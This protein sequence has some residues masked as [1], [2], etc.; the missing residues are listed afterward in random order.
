MTKKFSDI[1]ITYDNFVGKSKVDYLTPFMG[2]AVLGT[3]L[4]SF[5][6]I[7]ED[8][9]VNEKFSLT[10]TKAFTDI[11]SSPTDEFSYISDFARS[12][13][14]TILT[15]EFISFDVSLSAPVD[16]VSLADLLSLSFNMSFNDSTNNEDSSLIE[17][18]KSVAETQQATD[19]ITLVADFN[20]DLNDALESLDNTDLLLSKPVVD[21]TTNEDL[22]ALSIDFNRIFNDYIAPEELISKY[23]DKTA[24][25]DN[26]STASVVH[27]LSTKPFIDYQSLSDLIIVDSIKA[28]SDTLISSEVFERVV[29]FRREFNDSYGLEDFLS[30]A[31][32]TTFTDSFSSSDQLSMMPTKQFTDIFSSTDDQKFDIFKSITD[33][34]STTDDQKFDIFKSITDS[35]YTT[36]DQLSM[37]PTKQFTDIFSSTDDQKFDIFKSITDSFS[38]SD[39]QL[40]MMPTKQFTDIFSSSDQLSMMPT[41]QFTDIF[42]SSDDQKFDIFKSI[43]DEASVEDLIGVPDGITWEY[44]KTSNESVNASEN[45]NVTFNAY[46]S[47]IDSSQ[48]TEEFN[49]NIGKSFLDDS[50]VAD[51]PTFV[52]AA[53]RSFVETP[54]TTDTLFLDYATA[55]NE[56]EPVS[57]NLSISFTTEFSDSTA[58]FE[59]VSITAGNLYIEDV[60]A[61]DEGSLHNQGYA[62]DYFAEDYVG[63]TRSF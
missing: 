40:S 56:D 38:S 59:N 5:H 7:D 9:F 48:P 21:F 41:K 62:S 8:T 26:V 36:D 39:D 51:T 11:L 12:P 23:L 2:V 63:D 22:I 29:D 17:F 49:W 25:I 6:L 42:S 47:I 58:A 28:L 33:S 54:N 45:F 43:E 18:I 4:R 1:K 30:L 19:N 14:E 44:Y 24:F 15:A 46:R 60:I 35:F 53:N 55:L 52:F 20:R 13:N 27:I 57:D 32:G 31:Y 3:V 37:M 34:F 10:P 16:T 61:S 50:S